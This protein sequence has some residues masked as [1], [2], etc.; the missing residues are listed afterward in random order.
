MITQ[1][2]TL[3]SLNSGTS[4]ENFEAPKYFLERS[5]QKEEYQKKKKKKK[6]NEI[7]Q[8][9]TAFQPFPTLNTVAKSNPV[10]TTS[11][12]HLELV[13]LKPP[14]M[15]HLKISINKNPFLDLLKLTHDITTQTPLSQ[16]FL[17]LNEK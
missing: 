15:T 4:N 3:F 14:R 10:T 8:K 11:R 16:F 17:I 2:V 7:F 13:M 12:E 6:K 5:F 9:N 1:I